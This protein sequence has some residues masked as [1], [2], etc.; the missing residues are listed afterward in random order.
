[1]CS[2]LNEHHDE[3]LCLFND[4]SF[5]EECKVYL[6]QVLL[7]YDSYGKIGLVCVMLME[8]LS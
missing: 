5:M 4:L 1:M 7:K 3:G 2:F 8:A 6:V